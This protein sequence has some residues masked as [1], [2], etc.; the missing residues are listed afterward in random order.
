MVLKNQGVR[1][2]SVEGEG[3]PASRIPVFERARQFAE[4]HSKLARLRA[5]LFAQL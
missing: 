5:H 3:D 1:P 4:L 2:V